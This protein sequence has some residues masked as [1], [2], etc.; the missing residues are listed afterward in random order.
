MH[1][2]IFAAITATLVAAFG[3]TA[4]AEST[5]VQPAAAVTSVCATGFRGQ[6]AYDRLCLKKGTRATGAA[7]WFA[8]DA[9][10]KRDVCRAG[11]VRKMAADALNDVAYDRYR[12]HGTVLAGVSDAAQGDCLRLGYAD[13]VSGRAAVNLHTL[14]KGDCWVEM[15][16]LNRKHIKINSEV[17]CKG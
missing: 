1:K 5:D 4:V 2:R 12:N 7:L 10:S 13:A 16:Y 14:P 9:A 15:S 8:L 11:N 17:L 6:P 3:L